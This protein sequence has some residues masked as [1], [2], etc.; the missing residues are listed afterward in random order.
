MVFWNLAKANK[1]NDFNFNVFMTLSGHSIGESPL[2][3]RLGHGA[4][5]K[6][7]WKSNWNYMKIE[8]TSKWKYDFKKIFSN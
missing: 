8:T 2:M 1:H 3:D 4:G 5:L 7:K 6:P